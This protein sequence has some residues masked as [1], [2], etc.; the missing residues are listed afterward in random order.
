MSAV[1][2]IR[3]GISNS[4]DYS[5]IAT[6]PMEFHEL[7]PKIIVIAASPRMIPETLIA[8]A[9]YLMDRLKDPR[10]VS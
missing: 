2:Q 6:L 9:E 3:K 1:S 5:T 10:K 7:L 8:R 4:T